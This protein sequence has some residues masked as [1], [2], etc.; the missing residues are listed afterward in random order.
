[1]LILGLNPDRCRRWIRRL[2]MALTGGTGTGASAIG[3]IGLIRRQ[4]VRQKLRADQGYGR[5]AV[6]VAILT[7]NKATPAAICYPR[8]TEEVTP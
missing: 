6:A 8:T 5:S 1:M 4:I 2:M 3:F 7:E